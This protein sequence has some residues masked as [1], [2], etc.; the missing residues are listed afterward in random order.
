MF[1]G[2]P[3]CAG[4]TKG[5]IAFSKARSGDAIFCSSFWQNIDRLTGSALGCLRLFFYRYPQ[6]L[7]TLADATGANVEAGSALMLVDFW[8]VCRAFS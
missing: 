3:A 6:T 2:I 1:V 5:G 8:M 7:E 4:M